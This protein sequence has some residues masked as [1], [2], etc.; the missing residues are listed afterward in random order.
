VAH[1]QAPWLTVVPQ[2]TNILFDL[3]LSG[4]NALFGMAA[5][6]RI[7]VSI[8]VL[9]FGWGAFAF[10]SA[11]AGRR[12]WS[13]FPAILM[14]AYGWV[15]HVGFFN[16]YLSLGLCL[17]AMALVWQWNAR[18]AAAALAL[19]VVAF[20]AHALPVAWAVA[21]LAYRWALGRV[22]PSRQ[23]L[24]AVAAVAAMF[25]ARGAMALLIQTHAEPG[26][27]M[28]ITGADQLFV[29]DG[30]YRL[31]S[32]VLLAI[33][34]MRLADLLLG[35]K[36]AL[37]AG[38]PF[39]FCL[40]TAAAI[41]I[42]P[43]WVAIPGYKHALAFIA[44]RLS[45]PLAVCVC[46]LVAGSP[47]AP[48]RAWQ[49]AALAA[50]ALAFFGMLYRDEGVLNG[51]EDRLERL[52]AELPPGQRVV[53][54]VNDSVLRAGPVTHMIDRVCVGRCYSYANYEP[55]TAQFRVRVKGPNPIIAVTYGDSLGMQTGKYVVK[56]GDLPLYVVDLNP[57]G[58]LTIRSAPAGAPIGSTEV[59]LL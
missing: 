52:V 43:S 35:G 16:F 36:H 1:G 53:N 45:L 57:Q 9:A 47:S 21:L 56:P 22:G 33:W 37:A 48:V 34:G 11:V 2:A 42:F 17:W 12:A 49:G 54:A 6:Q 32:A 31:L 14:L 24:L 51:F 38:A 39:H 15:F 28:L 5:A 8:A 29:F 40:L 18:R 27:I 58:R 41:V 26:Q 19:L 3:M 46:A 30:K 25:L 4:L 13:I 23:A 59:S 7:A 50:A 55:S 44:E 20:V 10:V